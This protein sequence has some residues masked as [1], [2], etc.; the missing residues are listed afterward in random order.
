MLPLR[1]LKVYRAEKARGMG[2]EWTIPLKQQYPEGF[3]L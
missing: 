2:V 1:A 3:S